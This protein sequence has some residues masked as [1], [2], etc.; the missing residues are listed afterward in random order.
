[1]NPDK[2]GQ[3]IEEVRQRTQ[4]LQQLIS[5]SPVDQQ[6][7][8]IQAFE[9]LSIAL[10]ELRVAEEELRVQNEQLAIAHQQVEKE[11]LRYQELFDFAPDGYLV[12]DTDGKILE[13]NYAA[14]KV[15]EVPQKFLLGKPLINFIPLETRRAFRFQ[16]HRLYDQ[17]GMQEWEICLKTRQGNKFDASLNVTTVRDSTGNPLGWRWLLR[18]ITARKQAEEQMRFYE[19]QNLQLQEAALI[20]SQFLAVVSHELRTPMNTILG[21]SQLL[22]RRYYHIFPPELRNMVERIINSGKNLLALIEDILDFSNLE[23]NKLELRLQEF[24]LV[25]LVTA[26]TEELRFLAQQKNLTLAIHIDIQNP[27][28][29]NDSDRLRQVLVNLLA[30]AIKFTE[31]GGV[32][33]EVQQLNQNRVTLMV[34]DT[35]IGIAEAEFKDIFKEFWQVDLST[36]RRYG[37]AG[38]GLAI[39]DRLVRL[40]KGTITV[41]SKLGS[42]STFRIELPQEVSLDS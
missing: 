12:T 3:Q 20:K 26:T 6:H 28:V 38:L 42:G 2:F 16:L 9:E 22:L 17:E 25:E 1:M 37:G 35:G 18:D 40:M 33:V 31:S 23:A 41:E 13:A 7:L 39:V 21:F 8:L 11:R 4:T 27:T 36:T 5:E 29:V 34:K 15:L 19:R 24:N 32:F 14:A 30:N 10:E